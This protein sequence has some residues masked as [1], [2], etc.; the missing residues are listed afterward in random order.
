MARRLTKYEIAVMIDDFLRD[1]GHTTGRIPPHV[2]VDMYTRTE[3]VEYYN[4]MVRNHVMG[5]KPIQ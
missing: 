2:W 4:M 1:L 5:R 3:L